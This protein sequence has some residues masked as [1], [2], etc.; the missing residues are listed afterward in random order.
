MRG[1]RNSKKT[2]WTHTQRSLNNMLYLI[3]DAKYYPDVKNELGEFCV[4]ELE[5]RRL[6]KGINPTTRI[7]MKGNIYQKIKV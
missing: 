3:W 1:H 2:I 4:Q 7:I 5:C 6:Q